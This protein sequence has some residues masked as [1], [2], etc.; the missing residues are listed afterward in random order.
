VTSPPRQAG[1]ALVPDGLPWP[2][3]DELARPRLIA[4]LAERW[5]KPVT[6]VV[7]GPGFGKSAST[8]YP[9]ARVVARAS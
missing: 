9:P 1:G 3:A 8:R 7:A 6:L 4:R 5:V 2:T